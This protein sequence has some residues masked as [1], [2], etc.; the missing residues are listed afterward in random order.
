MQTK[1]AMDKRYAG[2]Y[3]GCE[4]SGL[5]EISKAGKVSW[6]NLKGQLYM[7]SDTTGLINFKTMIRSFSVK[8]MNDTIAGVY[9]NDR[10]FSLLE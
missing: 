2:V 6:G 3:D 1:I 9:S 10:Y 4:R 7:L 8:R 5:M